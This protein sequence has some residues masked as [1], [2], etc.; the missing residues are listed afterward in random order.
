ME[1]EEI[2]LRLAPLFAEMDKQCM[3]TD[4]LMDK[5]QW[6][7]FLTTMWSNLVMDPENLDLTEEDLEDAYKVI[8][9]EAENRLGG[10]DAL[11][12]AFRFLTT[13]DGERCMEKAKLRKSHKD[14]LL[15]FASMMVDPERHK[16]Y[17]A[18]IRDAT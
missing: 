7:I 4:H 1:S 9:K 10:K 2:S 12:D 18:E 3:V 11:V 16:Q 8:E 17:M 5:D 13:K 6:R 14:M 15:Y